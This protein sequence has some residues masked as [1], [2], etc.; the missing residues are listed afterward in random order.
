[1]KNIIIEGTDRT[2]KSTIIEG[3]CKHY[4]YDNIVVRHLAK[5]PKHIHKDEVYKWQMKAFIKEGELAK[6]LKS[7]EEDEFNYYENK[8]IYNRYYLGEYVYGIM[9]RNYN[10]D[11]ISHRLSEFEKQYINLSETKLITLVAS[12]EFL[13]KK[14]DG[15]S[16]SQNIDQKTKEVQLFSE[17]H[18]K[19]LIRDKMILKVD[20]EGVFLPK[21]HL[22]KTVLD[23][24]S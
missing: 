1:M 21:E 19:S 7:L 15:N 22:L 3:I 6:Y 8:I 16:F 9:F 4:E 12:P 2:G 20:R 17:I 13:M 18:D 5:P 11:F 24:I 14:E 10:E 23:F